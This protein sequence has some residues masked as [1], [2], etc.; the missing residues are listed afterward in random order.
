MPVEPFERF[1]L[2]RAFERAQAVRP[3]VV[4]GWHQMFEIDRVRV[5]T[6]DHGRLI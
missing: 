4:A 2:Q 5:E 1:G 3:L 6:C